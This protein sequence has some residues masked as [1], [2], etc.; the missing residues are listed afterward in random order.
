MAERRL[1]ISQ[2]RE[3]RRPRSYNEVRPDRVVP[4]LRLKGQ[5][6]EELGFEAGG[7]VRVATAPGR[8][9]VTPAREGVAADA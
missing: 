3:A 2:L 1:T 7:Q 4:F 9:V 8:L 6:L 5:W